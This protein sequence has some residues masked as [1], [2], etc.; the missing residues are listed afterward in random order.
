M[1]MEPA[2]VHCDAQPYVGVRRLVT[3]QRL[4]E[5][6]DELPG[7]FTWLRERGIAPAGPPFFR[8]NVIVMEGELEVEAGVPVPT[9]VPADPP[10]ISGVLPAGRYLSQL[11]VGE[12][13]GLADTTYR[14][15]RWAEA[16]ELAWDMLPGDRWGCRLEVYR[17]DPSAEPDVSKWE[18]ELLFK[19][20]D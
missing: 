15:L 1:P 20:A 18:T 6:A 9:E 8:Y 12:Y 19:L 2:V 14:L 4:S 10:L 17:T 11:H 3:Q 16:R 7:L 5:L 13:S